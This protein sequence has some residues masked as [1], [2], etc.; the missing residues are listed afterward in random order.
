MENLK[1]KELSLQEMENLQ[2][3]DSLFCPIYGIFLQNIVIQGLQSGEITPE[4][5]QLCLVHTT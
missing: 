3:G 1:I 5:P 2:G 4:K